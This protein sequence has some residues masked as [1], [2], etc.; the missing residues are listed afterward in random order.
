[1][2]E[3]RSML[4]PLRLL[5][6]GSNCYLSL[7]HLEVLKKR[8][9]LAERSVNVADQDITSKYWWCVYVF[10]SHAA[11]YFPQQVTNPEKYACC[12]TCG[13][14]IKIEFTGNLTKY[15]SVE[16]NVDKHQGSS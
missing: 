2:S 6:S 16:G 12:R 7:D 3:T 14:A 10:T 11:Q 15:F 1:M 9:I 13:A 5:T 8:N 4:S